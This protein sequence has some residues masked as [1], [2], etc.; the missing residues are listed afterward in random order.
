VEA[1]EGGQSLVN[2]YPFAIPTE[3]FSFNLF[4]QAFAAVQVGG[5]VAAGFR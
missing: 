2:R 3:A 5:G 4:K 1:G